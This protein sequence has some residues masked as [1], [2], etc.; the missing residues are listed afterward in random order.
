MSG[1]RFLD[2]AEISSVHTFEPATARKEHSQSPSKDFLKETFKQT[3]LTQEFDDSSP[4]RRYGEPS[5]TP[6]FTK[7]V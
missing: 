2:G 6:I 5:V 3:L 1:R 4:E 7:T